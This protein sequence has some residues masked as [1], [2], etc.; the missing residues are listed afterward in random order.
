VESEKGVRIQPRRGR[1]KKMRSEAE[2]QGFQ[3]GK[4][5]HGQEGDGW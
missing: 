3:V 5:I 4:I 2:T 1:S